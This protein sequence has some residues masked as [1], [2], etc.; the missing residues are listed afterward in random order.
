[1]IWVRVRVRV[2]NILCYPLTYLFS[3]YHVFNVK[4]C[5]KTSVATF[6]AQA[7]AE[8]GFRKNPVPVITSAETILSAQDPLDEFLNN[9]KAADGGTLVVDE[10]YLFDPAP[11]GN[12]TNTQ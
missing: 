11:K 9:V 12:V 8:L 5:G 7:M 10:A 1:M 4:G 3:Y 6:L 2:I